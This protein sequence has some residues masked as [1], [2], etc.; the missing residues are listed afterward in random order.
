MW[1]RVTSAGWGEGA[2][3]GGGA[4]GGGGGGDGVVLYFFFFFFVFVVGSFCFLYFF[5]LFFWGLCFVCFYF[6]YLFY[7]SDYS[8]HP[9][10]YDH[11]R[12]IFLPVSGA[13]CNLLRR[14]FF[15]FPA[16]S[17]PTLNGSACPDDGLSFQH[18]ELYDAVTI[19]VDFT[20]VFFPVHLQLHPPAK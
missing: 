19:P 13:A 1:G 18:G 3:G 5:F 9:L 12:L 6:C 16:L 2:V 11:V 4:A 10:P 17:A 7:Y 15:V 8:F 20:A 14:D